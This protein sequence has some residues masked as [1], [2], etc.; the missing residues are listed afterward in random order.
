MKQLGL[1]TC[2]RMLRMR[3]AC[4]ARAEEIRR[5]HRSASPVRRSRSYSGRLGRSFTAVPYASTSV[6]P[7]MNSVAS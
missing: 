2:T 6:E 7:C 3:S 4:A 1:L 5:C